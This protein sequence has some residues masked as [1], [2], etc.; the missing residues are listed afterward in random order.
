MLKSHMAS[1][2][3]QKCVQRMYENSRNVN[4]RAQANNF[5]APIPVPQR[6]TN[7]NYNR[8]PMQNNGIFTPSPILSPLEQAY[9]LTVPSYYEN[10]KP[11]SHKQSVP[12]QASTRDFSFFEPTPYF[13]P[14]HTLRRMNSLPDKRVIAQQPPPP[15]LPHFRPTNT[16]QPPNNANSKHLRRASGSESNSSLKFQPPNFYQQHPNK[17]LLK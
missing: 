12:I 2:T 14:T 8:Q 5:N 4:V 16:T 9:A 13:T 10:L 6:P 7:L 3:K 1:T 17:A 11:Q 15:P